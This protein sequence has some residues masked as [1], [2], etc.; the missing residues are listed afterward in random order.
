[1]LIEVSITR[2]DLP[3]DRWQQDLSPTTPAKSTVATIAPVLDLVSARTVI[4]RHLDGDALDLML[5]RLS[6]FHDA[7]AAECAI[8][9]HPAIVRESRSIARRSQTTQPLLAGEAVGDLLLFTFSAEAEEVAAPRPAEK[10]VITEIVYFHGDSAYHS[11][12]VQGDER[13][14]LRLFTR[15]PSANQTGRNQN[16]DRYFS[17]DTHASHE[18]SMRYEEPNDLP[19]HEH[20]SFADFLKHVGYDWK[21]NT[22]RSTDELGSTAEAA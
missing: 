13:D 6:V 2:S 10:H 18:Q 8:V 17:V 1:M 4:G 21:S 20:A 14:R 16:G 9:P 7:F 19:R 22:Y 3:V 12:D 15:K 5:Q 11:V